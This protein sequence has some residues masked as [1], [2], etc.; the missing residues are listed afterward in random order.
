VENIVIDLGDFIVVLVM[1]SIPA[2]NI[3]T[4]DA[5]WGGKGLFSLQFHVAV[6]H[7]KKSGL[8]IKQVRKHGL[9]QRPWRNVT[10]WLASP[11]LLSLLSCRTKDYQARD[12][13]THNAP[14]PPAPIT[15]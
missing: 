6:H 4:E 11:D 8:E 2:Q 14:P 5:S 3:M 7:Q 15:N 13:T 10:H 9:I 12:G 1:V